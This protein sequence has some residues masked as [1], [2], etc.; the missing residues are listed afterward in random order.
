MQIVVKGAQLRHQHHALVDDG[1]AGEGTD[2]GAGLLLFKLAA[3]DVEAAV[4]RF[5]GGGVRG[6]GEKALADAGHGAPRRG[7]QQFRAA[8]HVAPAK[9]IK[10]LRLRQRIE[11]AARVVRGDPVVRQKEHAHGV[12]AFPA[13]EN[14][15]LRRPAGKER[16]RQARE[17]AHA[18]A[19][20]A[21][22]VAAG[23]VRQA[24]DDGQ[25][26]GYGAVGGLSAQVDHRAHAA[27]FVFHLRVVE[28]TGACHGV[29]LHCH[30][31]DASIFAAI[32]GSFRP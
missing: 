13:E 6:T 7:A 14:A 1:A 27:G 12:F 2:V 3:E 32:P 24:F 5:P 26:I 17:D 8:G 30:A 23:A 11:D 19:G 18:V 22:G 29:F 9:H 28:R 25:R 15:R 16:V 21:R 20:G 31:F 4:E 10:P